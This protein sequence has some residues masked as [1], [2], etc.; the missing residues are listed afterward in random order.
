MVLSGPGFADDIKAGKETHLTSTNQRIDKLFVA[1]YIKFDRTKDIKGVL[2]CGA[3]KNV[4][5]ILAGLKNLKKDTKTW[6]IFITEVVKE[7]KAILKAN[8]AE[9]G[10]VNLACGIGD[11][12]LTCDMPSRNYQYGQELRKNPS[13]K[14]DK[15][16]EGLT[17]LNKIK[18][19]EI[20]IPD[21][22]IKLKDLMEKI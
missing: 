16:V 1:E 3:L 18:R 12:K 13:A 4:Y 22:A 8:G 10:T 19:G 2:M 6:Q 20:I 9:P 21:A 14:P 17:A 7:M 11:L 15:T 5:A